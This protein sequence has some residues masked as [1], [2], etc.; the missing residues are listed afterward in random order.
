MTV[1]ETSIE[2]VVEPP[3]TDSPQPHHLLVV[4]PA[5]ADTKAET[6]LFTNPKPN[7]EQDQETFLTTSSA[8]INPRL[9]LKRIAT[10]VSLDPLPTFKADDSSDDDNNSNSSSSARRQQHL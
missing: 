7:M 9:T 6:T 2:V 10:S 3:P 4:G 1:L 5:H 8:T